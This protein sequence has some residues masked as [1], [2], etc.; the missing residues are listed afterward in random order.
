MRAVHLPKSRAYIRS[1]WLSVTKS[2]VTSGWNR[3]NWVAMSA[4][5]VPCW[6]G[7]AIIATLGGQPGAIRPRKAV[8]D[9]FHLE[10]HRS[11]GWGT[12]ILIIS[13][14]RAHGNMFPLP[15][16]APMRE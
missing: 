5:S 11:G 14:D 3:K 7:S 9:N 12:N 16:M 6:T 1:F 10:G 15:G 2:S 4:S 8:V 13:T